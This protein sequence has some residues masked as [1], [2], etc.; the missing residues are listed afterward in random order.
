M[1]DMKLSEIDENNITDEI[2]G[3]VLFNV[4]KT[5]Y[6]EVD[7][8]I[9]FGCHIKALLDERL[10]H[11]LS[12]LNS[13]KVHKIIISGG[14]GEKGD[15]NESDYMLSFFKNNWVTDNI[16]VEDK[17]KNSEENVLNCI[18]ILKN[19]NLL[20]KRILLVS[21]EFHMRKL[22]GMFKGVSADLDLLYDYPEHSAFSFDVLISND[23]LR[24][25]AVEQVIKIK[26]LAVQNKIPDDDIGL[27]FSSKQL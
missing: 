21:N 6:E 15:F 18:D 3:D 23:A 5:P 10:N 26:N 27:S 17:S 9:V 24:N 4:F 25:I 11:A 12:I 2:I 8:L 22:S 13:K 7:V 1:V 19:E 14:V 16:I 20:D